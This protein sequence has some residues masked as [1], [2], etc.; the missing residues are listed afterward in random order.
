MA[1]GQ[2][3]DQ[4]RDYYVSRFLE[5]LQ[6][7]SAA[8]DNTVVHEPA[9][10]NSEG[11]VVTAGELELPVRGDV[12]VIRDG[13][14]DESLQIDTDEMLTFDPVEFDWPENELRV[15]L[16][17]FQWN[18]IQLRIYGLSAKTD[19]S[20]LREWFL[21][22]FQEEDPVADELL[23]GVHF[24]SDPEPQEGCS[25]VSIDLGT[26]PVE[27][28]EEL[29]DAIGRLGADRVEIGQFDENG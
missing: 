5:V 13:V 22:W 29:L 6:E 8:P 19:W 16:H 1:L 28:L 27:S 4:I 18:W 9:Y 25:Q 20:P 10:C 21:R 7:H 24:L 2:L 15:E 23:G 17:P 11:E 12:L 14:I 3:L 26:A